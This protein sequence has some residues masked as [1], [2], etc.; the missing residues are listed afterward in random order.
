MSNGVSLA[1][2]VSFTFALM[3]GFSLVE[4]NGDHFVTNL[5]PKFDATQIEEIEKLPSDQLLPMT[6]LPLSNLNITIENANS[7]FNDL[8]SF[9]KKFIESQ[10]EMNSE[11]RKLIDNNFWNLV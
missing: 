10:S 3:G 5:L 9:A 1:W 7:Q 6:A 11:I 8:M 2:P 4:L